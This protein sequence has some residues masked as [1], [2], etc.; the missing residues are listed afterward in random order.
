[1]A[2]SAGESNVTRIRNIRGATT[3]VADAIAVLI[4]STGQLGTINSRRSVK[5]DIQDMA[6]DS[7][8]IYNLRPVTFVYND[9]AS[10]TIQYG[11]IAE[12]AAE[13]FPTI[14][15]Y[16]ANGQPQTIQYHV[17]P[18][19]MLNELQKLAARVATLEARS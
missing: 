7:A 11:L 10:E 4:D 2:V 14:V 18:A 3:G 8:N 15:V 6:T 9:D 16:D 13:A 17:L 19:L 5:H 1:N 12:E